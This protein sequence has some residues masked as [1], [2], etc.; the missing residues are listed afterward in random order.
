MPELHYFKTDLTKDLK[1]SKADL[2]SILLPDS[3]PFEIFDE[4]DD[5]AT[6]EALKLDQK[7]NM[8]VAQ[9]VN[10][11]YHK[12]ALLAII[13]LIQ[14]SVVAMSKLDDQTQLVT[15]C[16]DLDKA[17]DVKLQDAEDKILVE[18]EKAHA[19]YI[20]DKKIA[21]AY[22]R[23]L[24]TRKVFAVASIGGSLAGI[25][26]SAASIVVS[27]P[28][29][30]AGVVVSTYGLAKGIKNSIDVWKSG[31]QET[32]ALRKEIQE[33][34][35]E[36]QQKYTSA[37]KTTKGE[38]A[39]T[40]LE[41]FV[42]KEM[43]SITGL[44]KKIED[45]AGKH[46]KQVKLQGPLMAQLAEL[47]DAQELL[48]KDVESKGGQIRKIAAQLKAP[49]LDD[50]LK[51]K[52]EEL[53]ANVLATKEVVKTLR[54]ASVKLK[55]EEELIEEWQELVTLLKEKKPGYVKVFQKMITISELGIGAAVTAGAAGASGAADTADLV[56][57]AIDVI[58]SAVDMNLNKKGKK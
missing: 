31:R 53:Q 35:T 44:R 24:V 17:V 11:H 1:N 50:A 21:K 37:S 13:K 27:G 38:L 49:G 45:F 4:M 43:P 42:A 54:L 20:K 40:A 15:A 32:K 41:T 26:A 3:L 58:N 34:I 39:A 25:G 46:A 10:A 52:L 48:V 12:G 9:A 22:K 55:K 23:K 7:F 14:D 29:G 5:K 16:A 18:V 28:V 30:A 51:Q 6:V 57:G 47:M 19:A 36:L 56:L 33:T 8:A 2:G